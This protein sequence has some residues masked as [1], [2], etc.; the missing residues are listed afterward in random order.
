MKNLVE[1]TKRE[2]AETIA[3]DLVAVLDNGS[4]LS[5]HEYDGAEWWEVNTGPVRVVN[6]KTFAHV[7]SNRSCRPPQP[8][9]RLTCRSREGVPAPIA[10]KQVR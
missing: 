7:R 1:E 10:S 4:W 6:P 8:G 2:V 3:S 9:G 5:R